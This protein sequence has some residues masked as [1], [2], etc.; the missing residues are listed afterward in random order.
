[1]TPY[2]PGEYPQST[3]NAKEQALVNG[4]FRQNQAL[5]RKYTAVEK[6]YIVTEVEP[7]FL[8]ALVYQLTGFGKVSTLT[9]LQHMLYS[10]GAIEKID[11][12]ENAVKT[13]GTYDS[14]ET[15]A[16][17]IKKL[18]MGREFAI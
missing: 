16:Q 5:F 10:Y 6:N 9:M 11:L 1:M 12:E 3:R 18:E 13:M 2:N 14:A 17:L 7:V 8:S 4:K 15:L